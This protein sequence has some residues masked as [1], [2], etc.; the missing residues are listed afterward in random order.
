MKRIAFLVIILLTLL[1]FSACTGL[2]GLGGGTN[3]TCD[4]HVDSDY[5]AQCDVCGKY[6]KHE[7][8][9]SEEYTYNDEFHYRG[10]ICHPT[11]FAKDKA[12]HTIEKRVIKEPTCTE[13]GM[14]EYYCT[15]CNYVRSETIYAKWHSFDITV[16]LSDEE[17]HWRDYTCG[18]EIEK[19]PHEW[20]EGV[21]TTPPTCTKEGV[22]TYT[23]TTDYCGVYYTEP[24]EIVPH[25]ISTSLS[26]DDTHHW[27][28]YICGCDDLIEKTEHT[29][30]EKRVHTI[31]T[32]TSEG[33]Y[34]QYCTECY[35]GVYSP[36][37][38]VDHEYSDDFTFDREGHW[39]KA[40]CGCDL[41]TPEE[42]HSF[43]IK[44][45]CTECG[46][47]LTA[48]DGFIYVLSN[49][50]TEYYLSGVE[51]KDM[52]EAHVPE[53]SLGKPVTKILSGAFKDTKI[54]SVKIPSTVVEIASDAFSGCVLEGIEVDEANERYEC[55]SGALIDKSE[56]ALL[57]GANK[58]DTEIKEGVIK[59][60]DLAFYGCDK[61]EKLT[62]PASV[63]QIGQNAFFGVL[64]QISWTN[65]SLTEITPYAFAGYLGKEF[66][67]PEKIITIRENAFLNSS[68]QITFSEDVTTIEGYAFKGCTGIK[69]LYLPNSVASI[70]KGAFSG[71]AGITEINVPFVGE[72]SSASGRE[73]LLGHI[74]GDD[75]YDGGTL[76]T[77]FYS[78]SSSIKAY[79]PSG[80]EKI[81]VRGVILQFGALQNMTMV[82]EIVIEEGV[83][84]IGDGALRGCTDLEKLTIPFVGGMTNPAE[85]TPETVF[86][87]IFGES[88]T[89]SYQYYDGS[90]SG[91]RF[92]IPDSIKE[93]TVLGGTLR[94]G[95]FSNC[96][97]IEKI[98]LPSEG[99]LT[100]PGNAFYNCNSLKSLNI[101]NSVTEF[102]YHAFQKINCLEELYVPSG[103][104]NIASYAFFETKIDKVIISDVDAWCGIEF[105]DVRSNP[106]YE[107]G[108][109]L[110]LNGEEI[111]GEIAI[112]SG[113]EVI[114]FAAFYGC[115]K[116]TGLKLP[117][118]V[119]EIS[120]YAFYGCT[121]LRDVE[122]NEG[123]VYISPNAFEGAGIKT[124]VFPSTLKAIGTSAFSG[125]ENLLMVKIPSN[126]KTFA[127]LSFFNCTKLSLVYNLS[128]A[129]EDDILNSYLYAHAR[130]IHTAEEE[131]GIVYDE[132]GF[133]FLNTDSKNYLVDYIGEKT[134]VI[135][136]KTY[137][138]TA[139]EM[140]T[141]VFRDSNITSVDTNG[142]VSSL[143]NYAFANT[144]VESAILTGVTE[145][146]EGAF[147]NCAHLTNLTLDSSL[148]SIKQGAFANCKSLTEISLNQTRVTSI[149][150]SVF[151]GCSA[152]E[153]VTLQPA[154]TKLGSLA[155][156]NCKSLTSIEN[157]SRIATIG[158][159]TFYGCSNLTSISLGTVSSVGE[160]SFMYCTG[161]QSIS[162]N[163][164]TQIGSSAFSGCTSLKSLTSLY[165]TTVTIGNTAFDG[166]LSLESI[167]L[168]EMIVGEYAFRGCNSFALAQE[169]TLLSVGKEAFKGLPLIENVYFSTTTTSDIEIGEGAFS[170]SGLRTVSLPSKVTKIGNSAF[171][172]C[173][174]LNT[175]S[176]GA[177]VSTLD[178]DNLVFANAGTDGEGITL[179]IGK[180]ASVIPSNLFYPSTSEEAPKA[181][182]LKRIELEDTSSTVSITIGENAF[183]NC[184]YLELITLPYGLS[185]ELGT[186]AFYGCTAVKK[187]DFYAKGSFTID[188]YV[189][190]WH[191]IEYNTNAFA[192]LGHNTTGVEVAF[193]AGT[194]TIPAGLFFAPV[195]EKANIAK[196]TFE[197]GCKLTEVGAYSFTN[198]GKITSV[199]LPSGVKTIGDSA[200]SGCYGVEEI[201]VPKSITYIGSNAFSDITGTLYL[202]VSL[203]G[204]GWSPSWSNTFRGT[205]VW[206]YT[207]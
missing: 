128:A 133:G 199:K 41:I 198:M 162:F 191:P 8:V 125:C 62:I 167:D 124:A 183:K 4:E 129:D 7:H 123:L 48:N 107:T 85:Q 15:V 89:G 16:W 31:P 23:C 99:I 150:D 142:A 10:T 119:T 42:P 37:E 51:N 56:G 144:K 204:S 117:S 21:V 94:Y 101:P 116:I 80:L 137:N 152:L 92:G 66:S 189:N 38:M 127:Q 136:P 108:A 143:G 196:I 151:N 40:S 147:N 13:N 106:L 72:G 59:I 102:G 206:D 22:M 29:L 87:F 170:G 111:N 74:F 103:L 52:T 179:I 201:Y 6:I 60:N 47:Q 32:C 202:G 164:I 82:K 121:S 76:V 70:G 68:A 145:I 105:T 71:C 195:S 27:Y 20:D 75:Q 172:S 12:D 61:I 58:I 86:G 187:I 115:E 126:V 109:K 65:T 53:N 166:C 149:E 148:S 184:T 73:A 104:T 118:S 163:R 90:T 205:K 77:Q 169:N 96:T 45:Q 91:G 97:S 132:N 36:I 168:K 135:L 34:Y 176:Y 33:K 159:A 64:A 1:L 28:G 157:L 156:Y 98:T 54:T 122:F 18:C 154:T 174:Y 203:A 14:A 2:G 24:I 9:F 69:T 130:L 178:S 95:A 25:E 67:V 19:Y 44:N 83:S 112:S 57:I 131:G 79:V 158:D 46:Y 193:K 134:D 140:G 177:N 43:D 181:P 171:E 100:I 153:R 114:P 165:K 188:Y 173:T 186:H 194:T 63:G 35:H 180:K 161:L 175:V 26:S 160:Q 17:S 207:E 192:F 93:V 50:Y 138:G 11:N 141:G 113:A 78:S 200:F 49:D 3:D 88:S 81:T 182:K 197:E 5:N 155:F 39:H 146:S 110:Y 190:A 30:T 120:K 55:V 139:Y 84:M 185:G